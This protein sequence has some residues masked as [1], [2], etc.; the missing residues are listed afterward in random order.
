MG[1]AI[2]NRFPIAG[3]GSFIHSFISV[4]NKPLTDRTGLNRRYDLINVLDNR[5]TFPMPG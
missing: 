2:P 3:F 1:I 5:P 4:K